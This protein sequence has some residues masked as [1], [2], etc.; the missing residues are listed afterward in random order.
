L[1]FRGLGIPELRNVLQ[2]MNGMPPISPVDY[3]ALE[4]PSS[5]LGGPRDERMPVKR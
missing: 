2:Y 5:V 4:D 1:Y 3:E